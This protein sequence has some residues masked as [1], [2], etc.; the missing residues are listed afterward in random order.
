MSRTKLEPRN[1]FFDLCDSSPSSDDDDELLGFVSGINSKR[2]SVQVPNKKVKE[3]TI[4]NQGGMKRER[5]GTDNDTSTISRFASHKKVKVEVANNDPKVKQEKGPYG[6][7][8]AVDDALTTA[9]TNVNS[10]NINVDNVIQNHGAKPTT[11][12]SRKRS[13]ADAPSAISTNVY[14]KKIKTEGIDSQG[15]KRATNPHYEKQITAG[16]YN[17]VASTRVNSITVNAGDVSNR[18]VKRESSP[19]DERKKV[20][21]SGTC[22]CSVTPNQKKP[23]ANPEKVKEVCTKIINELAKNYG[24]GM[25]SVPLDTLACAVGYKC[26]RS[27]VI[28]EAVKALVKDGLMTKTSGSCKLTAVGIERYAPKIKPCESPE[29]AMDQ[30]WNQFLMKLS[31]D[32]KTSGRNVAEAARV[33]WDKLKDGNYHSREALVALTTFGMVRSTGYGEMMSA[34]GQRQLGFTEN[35]QNGTI[36]FTDKVFPFGRPKVSTV[37]RVK[38]EHY[39][40]L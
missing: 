3:E 6:K 19:H 20:V 10:K 29:E 5:D 39:A 13:G 12:P 1:N 23:R 25:E 9:S 28:I 32:P 27:D 7:K 36:R 37:R 8:R 21:S 11:S 35:G 15:M 2:T 14:S 17:A 31:S 40:S 18:G 22:T 26:A 33:V 30:F 24:F 4:N 16:N 34:L 38:A